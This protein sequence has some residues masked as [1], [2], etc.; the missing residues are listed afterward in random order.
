MFYKVM[1]IIV[2]FFF[3]FVFRMKVKGYENMPKE[4]GVIVAFNHRSN[5]DPVI[6][7]LSS[8]RPLTFMA[9][10]ELFKNWFFGGLIKKLGAFPVKRGRGD[11]GAIKAALKILDDDRVMLMFPEG[12]RIKDDRKVKAKPG[13]A[14]IAQRA[15]VPV[16][17]VCIS[18]KYKWMHK[19]TIT[20][21]KPVTLEEYYDKKMDQEEIQAAADGILEN[22]RALQVK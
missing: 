22:I 21:G 8:K 14:L 2:R 16:V 11:I 17:P 1:H 5:L 4:G 15:K 10:E 18:G 7:A 19:V 3:R 6:A 12:H 20:Y 13:V 9:K